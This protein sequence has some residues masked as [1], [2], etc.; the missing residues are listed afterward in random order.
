MPLTFEKKVINA[1]IE[2]AMAEFSSADKAY[3]DGLI[4][5]FRSKS[6]EYRES[7]EAR[8]E[9]A[10]KIQTRFVEMVNRIINAF[11]YDERRRTGTRR[12]EDE[13]YFVKVIACQIGLKL[14]S[15]FFKQIS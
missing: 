5:E 4:A 6:K 15:S 12:F 13:E 7:D 11:P 14:Y 3:I 9:V 8:K 1:A 10:N 2:A